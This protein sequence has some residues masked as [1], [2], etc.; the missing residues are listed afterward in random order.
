[1]KLKHSI[2]TKQSTI[3]L[4]GSMA[5]ELEKL[6]Y[7]NNLSTTAFFNTVIGAFA[8]GELKI[9]QGSDSSKRVSGEDE[10]EVLRKLRFTIKD[11][12]GNIIY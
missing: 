8:E 1:M 6:C 4:Y 11:K 10:E 9:S 2:P 7:Y 5:A 12:S 3:T